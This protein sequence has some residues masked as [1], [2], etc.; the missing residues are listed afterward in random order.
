[1]ALNVVVL[2]TVADEA[3]SSHNAVNGATSTV[4]FHNVQL[5]RTTLHVL[6]TAVLCDAVAT[7]HC[8]CFNFLDERD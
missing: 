6:Q 8:H 2:C 3:E 4:S 1:M 7:L 5:Y